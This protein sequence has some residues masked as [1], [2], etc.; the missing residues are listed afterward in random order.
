MSSS[1][2]SIC[3]KQLVAVKQPLKLHPCRSDPFCFRSKCGREH[4][5]RNQELVLFFFQKKSEER[6]RCSSGIEMLQ[7][8]M[9]MSRRSID[10]LFILFPTCSVLLL[11]STQEGKHPSITT[12][13][14]TCLICLD[15]SILYLFIRV[16]FIS[17]K[18]QVM[19]CSSFVCVHGNL[20]LLF[21][22]NTSFRSSTLSISCSCFSSC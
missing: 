12:I 20:V 3:F 16:G 15:P 6:K 21:T 10:L 7:V 9:R 8:T 13:I 14:W 11:I 2:S 18:S 4:H 1:S 22:C 17:G 19:L 5:V